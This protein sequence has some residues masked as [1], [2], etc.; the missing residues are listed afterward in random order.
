[1]LSEVPTV[2]IDIVEFTRNSGVLP[3]EFLAHRLG[4]IPLSAKNVDDMAY[5]RD[6]DCDAYCPA[7]SVTLTLHARCQNQAVMIVSAKDLVVSE[8]ERPNDTVGTPVIMGPNGTGCTV[9][10]L[11]GGQELSV[12]CIA[13]KGIAKE[14]SKW[15]PTAA[16]GFEYDPHNNLKHTSYWYENDPKSEWPASKNA[17]EEEDAEAVAAK[18]GQAAANRLVLEDEP[19]K[20]YFNVESIGGL[21]PDQVVQQGVKVLQQKLATVLQVLSGRTEG[22]GMLDGEE[23]APRSPEVNGYGVGGATNYGPGTTYG[24]GGATNYGGGAGFETAYQ[25]EQGQGS[26]WGGGDGGRTSYGAGTPYGGGGY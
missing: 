21:E 3:D 11:T 9:T 8:G 14:H 1:M 22:D 16:I 12:R 26:V 19:R 25:R 2:A 5:S 6:C 24:A 18:E 17:A 4:L 7:C 15:C 13:K 23:Y 10:K 20:F